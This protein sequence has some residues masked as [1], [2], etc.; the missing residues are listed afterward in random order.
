MKKYISFLIF[1]III[2]APQALL[3]FQETSLK[4]LKV[5]KKFNRRTFP[6]DYFKEIHQRRKENAALHRENYNLTKDLNKKDAYI[7]KLESKIQSL[8]KNP[9]IKEHFIQE[10]KSSNSSYQKHH[11]KNSKRGS[12]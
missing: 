5:T 7:D 6:D 11:N 10:S 4:N 8:Q 1:F 12:L 2:R 9:V 3:C